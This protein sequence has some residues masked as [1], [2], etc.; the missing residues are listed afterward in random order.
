MNNKY[1]RLVPAIFF[2]VMVTN[3]ITGQICPCTVNAGPDKNLCEPGGNIQ[4]NGSVAGQPITVEW[5]PQNGLSN[6]NSVSP[7][8][9]VDQTTIYTLTAKCVSNTNLVTNANFNAGNTGFTSDYTYS[10][11]NLLP[12]G[13]YTVTNNPQSVHPGFAPCGDHTGGGQMMVINGA[14]TPNQDVWCQTIPVLPNTDYAFETWVASVVAGSPALLQ[15]SINGSTI[16]PVF[17][18]PNSTCQWEKFTSTWNSG[19]STSATICIVNQNTVLGGNDFALDDI[20]FKEVCTISDKMTVFVNPVKQTYK[21]ASICQGQTYT[22]AGQTFQNEGTYDITLKTWKGCD[23]IITLDLTVIEVEAEIDPPFKL[24]C[25]LTEIFLYGDKSSFGPE[26]TYKWTTSNGSIISDP[27]QNTVIVNKPGKYTLTVTYN[28]GTITCSQSTFVTVETDYTKPVISAGNNGLITCTDTTLVLNGS[29][30]SPSDNF[31]IKWTTP[32]G[33]ILSKADSLNPLIGS[34][35][36]YILTVTS[37]YTGCSQ[38][39]TVFIDKD[40]TLPLA[41]ISGKDI[42]NCYQNSVWLNGFA[43]DN[44]PGFDFNWSTPN[45]QFNS[46]TDSLAVNINS[47]GTYNLTIINKNTGCKS[48]TSMTVS[49]DFAAPFAEAGPQDTLSCALIDL[50]LNAS[51]NLPDSLV[52]INW[53]TVTGKI[54]SGN[55]SLSIL[56]GSP[57]VYHISV[58]NILNGCFSNDSVMVVKDINTPSVIDLK[59]KTL[60]CKSPAVVIDASGSSTGPEFLYKWT[61]ANGTINGPYDQTTLSVD[62]TGT[63]VLT[64]INQTNGCNVSDTLQ[65]FQDKNYPLA[66]AGLPDQLTC[67]A[68]SLSLNGSQSSTGSEFKYVW[69]AFSGG[70][71]I[72]GISNLNPLIDKPGLYL[73]EVTN[74]NNGCIS[75]DSVQ[76]SIDTI[77]PIILVPADLTITCA[78]PEITINANNLSGPGNYKYSWSTGSGNFVSGQQSLTP[79]VNKPG[80]YTLI[81]TNQNNGC[82]DIAITAVISNEELPAVNG[83]SDLVLTCSAPVKSAIA[84]VIYNGGNTLISWSSNNLPVLSGS[85]TLNPQIGYPGIYSIT[86]IDTITGCSANDM[87]SVTM[88]TIAPLTNL[89]TPDILSC[90]ILKS[91]LGA[92]VTNNNWSYAWSTTNGNIVGSAVGNSILADKSGNYYLTVIDSGNGCTKI[93]TGTINED[94]NPPVISAGP[95]KE[96]TCTKKKVILEGSIQGTSQNK[97]FNWLVNGQPFSNSNIIAPEVESV[98]EYTLIVT[99]ET[100]GCTADDTVTVTENNNKPSDFVTDITAPGCTKSGI[101]TVT[102]VTGGIG[103]YVYSINGGPYQGQNIFH[104]IVSGQYNISIKDQNGCEFQKSLSVPEPPE[105]TAELPQF[106]TIEYGTGQQLLPQL[107]IDIKNIEKVIWVPVAGLSCSD[108]LEPIASPL[109]ETYYKVTVTD[110]TGCTASAKIQVRVLKDFYLYVPNAFSPNADGTNDKWQIFGD[111]LK[112]VKIKRLQIFDRWGELLFEAYDFQVNDPEFGWNGIFHGNYLDP[113]VFVYYFEAEFIDGSARLYKGD[114]NLMR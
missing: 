19:S 5:T 20:S 54:L 84:T 55:D 81:T 18:A 37:F 77:S 113:G 104:S 35:G 101:V 65:I 109:N 110:I 51:V 27:T 33:K 107:N 95:D 38:E 108:C 97:T 76:I 45:G 69:S 28:D 114:I 63:Y 70:N 39:D 78:S 56:I 9:T 88:D 30:I 11:T 92:Q 7:V 105:L 29:V 22:L 72:S 15:F 99:N 21:Q 3:K 43:S 41:V 53:S 36:F 79:T 106:I 103:P 67:T 16:G 93:Y 10:A 89:N 25:G 57:A 62:Q 6:P 74:I 90:K 96:I 12:E 1:F 14:G 49:G 71:I 68:A 44:G 82:T 26:Y 94:K 64:I 50:M 47:P 52:K 48:N 58:M 112:V 87:I 17:E 102:T 40:P 31:S 2:I 91:V 42:L 66:E 4:L 13:I 60:T 46:N 75:K 85:N 98:G 8:A 73:L 80:T 59:D 100:N 61:T 32:N 86:V 24:D 34:P 23:S 83:G 111:P